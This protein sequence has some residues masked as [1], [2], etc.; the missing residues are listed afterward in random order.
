MCIVVSMSEIQGGDNGQRPCRIPTAA[1]M[2][3]PRLFWVVRVS[4]LDN[5]DLLPPDIHIFTSSRQPWVVLPEG[6]P[7]VAEYYDHKKYWPQASLE[8][9][10]A[11]LR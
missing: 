3:K 5:P 1:V 7:A 10:E 8:R 9:R 4:T 2:F 6:T 11:I